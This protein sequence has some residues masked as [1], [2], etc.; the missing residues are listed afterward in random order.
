M[1]L[2]I[3]KDPSSPPATFEKSKKGWAGILPLYMGEGQWFYPKFFPCH[4]GNTKGSQ[5]MIWTTLN[6]W[7]IALT[8]AI[9]SY[10]PDHIIIFLKVAMPTFH[11]I[12][13]AGGR[14]SVARLI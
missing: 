11:S 4:R 3:F 12:R 6:I 8:G 14:L 13:Q 2:S 10:L 9:H 7:T 5:T 1:S